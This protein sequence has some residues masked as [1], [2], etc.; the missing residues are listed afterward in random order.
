MTCPLCGRRKGKRACPAKDVRICSGC[1]GSKRKVEIN[2]PEDC[3]FLGGAHSAAWEGRETEKRR[4]QRRV[5]P[6]VA[7]LSEAQRGLFLLALFGLQTVRERHDQLDDLLLADAFTAF[8]KTV[9]TRARGVL[10]EHAPADLRA[11]VLMRDLEQVFQ[12]EGRDGVKRPP[13]DSDLLAVLKAYE[14]ALVETR[15]EDPAPT[16]FL[17]TAARLVADFVATEA[18]TA[19]AAPEPPRIIV[20]P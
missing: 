18:G 12:V 7:A 5:G 19:E 17:D 16:A 3:R 4:D 15:R 20:E 8:R 13:S 1:C 14:T 11:Q 6:H 10:Y 2:C 9:E